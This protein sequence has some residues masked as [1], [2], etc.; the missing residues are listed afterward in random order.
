MVKERKIS[1]GTKEF[2]TFKEIEVVE[3]PE[4]DVY[5]QWA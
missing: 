4:I 3:F 5:H 1:R 2:V